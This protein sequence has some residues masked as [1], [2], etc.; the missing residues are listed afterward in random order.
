MKNIKKTASELIIK[1]KPNVSESISILM[2]STFSMSIPLVMMLLFV[3]E[4]G[5]TTLKCKRLEPTQV[6]CEKEESKFFGLVE[7]PPTRFNLKAT[8]K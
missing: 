2:W 3:S 8:L 5:V 7:Q 4:I 1:D 6:S